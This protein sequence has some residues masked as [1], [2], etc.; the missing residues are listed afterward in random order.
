MAV[1]ERAPGQ[2]LSC[3]RGLRIPEVNRL[4]RGAGLALEFVAHSSRSLTGGQAVP[5]AAPHSLLGAM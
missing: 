4:H 1:T 5:S 2:D 3:R